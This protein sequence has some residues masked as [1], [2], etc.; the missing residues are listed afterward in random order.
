MARWFI[1]A[2]VVLVII[3]LVLHFL[4][5]VFNWFGKLP[6]DIHI[7]NENTKVMFPLTSMILVSVALSLLLSI[8]NKLS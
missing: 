8:F 6:G 4:P 2:G 7:E 1:L 3:G 5:N